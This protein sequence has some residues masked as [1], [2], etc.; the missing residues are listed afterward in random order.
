MQS[1]KLAALAAFLCA[2]VLFAQA[3]DTP[4]PAAS[5][6]APAGASTAAKPV[7]DQQSAG[8]H[9]S[10]PIRVQ[11]NEVIV[12]VTVTDAQAG[13]SPISP[14]KTFRFSKT[15]RPSR[16]SFSAENEISRW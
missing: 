4:K 16:S 9:E 13:S 3:P 11:V 1:Q 14:K 7:S 6:A 12:P 15:I 2:S 5:K 10:A 8:N